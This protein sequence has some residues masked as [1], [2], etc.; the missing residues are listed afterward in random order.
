M[1][2]SEF[3]PVHINVSKNG[4]NQG[5]NGNLR[6]EDSEGYAAG[7]SAFLHRTGQDEVINFFLRHVKIMSDSSGD[8]VERKRTGKRNG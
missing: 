7:Q 2:E 4:E 5:G 1:S 3:E 8:K 6:T